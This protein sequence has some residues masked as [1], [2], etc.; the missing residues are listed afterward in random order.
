MVSIVNVHLQ[1]SIVSNFKDHM[2]VV[3]KEESFAGTY[4]Q[5]L[6]YVGFFYSFLFEKALIYAETF[7]RFKVHQQKFK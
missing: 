4:S 1:N 5:W 7:V 3:D 2:H 6:T